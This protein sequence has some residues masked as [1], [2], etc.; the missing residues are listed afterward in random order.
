MIRASRVRVKVRVSLFTSCNSI[1]CSFK[2]AIRF[3]KFIMR[4]IIYKV[5]WY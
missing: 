4:P 2:I 5:S 1:L 3:W